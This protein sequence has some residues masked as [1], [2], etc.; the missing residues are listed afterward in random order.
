MYILML[1]ENLKLFNLTDINN[2]ILYYG[3]TKT[4]LSSKLAEMR[5]LYKL[6]RNCNNFKSVFD[7]CGPDNLI[8]GLVDVITLNDIDDVNKKI[9]ELSQNINNSQPKEQ[10]QTQ[11]KEQPQ[12]QPTEQPQI[13]LFEQPNITYKKPKTTEARLAIN[14]NIPKKTFDSFIFA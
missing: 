5:Y 14:S 10:Q 2:N 7:R 3:H 12:N 9:N 4:N 8:I 1:Y 13:K 11:P 6:D